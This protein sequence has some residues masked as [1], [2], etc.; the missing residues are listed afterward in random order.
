MRNLILFTICISLTFILSSDW[1]PDDPAKW[2]Q[3]PDTSTNGID[4]RMDRSD[5]VQRTL[6][7]DFEC[8]TTELITDI[9][10]WGSW[11]WDYVA[12]INW[13]ELSIWS[14]APAGQPDPFSHPD[15]LL[16]SKTFYPGDW[17]QRLYYTLPGQD[18]E[19]W[20]DPY[21]GDLDPMGD[22]QI[23][24]Y[25]FFIEEADA[26]MQTGTTANPIIYWLVIKT[27]IS[28]WEGESFGWKTR[29]YNEHFNDDAVRYNPF[30]GGW[31]ELRYP[32]GHPLY[33][34]SIDLSFVITGQEDPVDEYDLGDA[35]EG[36]GKI[37]YPSTMMPG[38]FP[39]CINVLPSGYVIHGPGPLFSYFGQSYDLESDGDAG[40][41]PNCFPTYDDDECFGDGDAGLIIPDSYT[42]DP[43]INVVTC[44]LSAGSSLGFPCA[45]A[46]WGTDID[47]DVQNQSTADRFVNVLFDWNQNGY[48][49][50]DAST[51]CLGTMTPEHVLV[52]FLVP[53]GYT[54]PLSGLTPPSFVIGPNT[55]Y[56]WSRFTISDIPVTFGEWDGSGD[57]GDGETED[58]LLHVEEETL[59]EFDF[60]DAP[61]GDN[62]IAYPSLGV[63]GSFPTC[64][65]VGPSGYIQ[66]GFGM[67][68]AWF[69]Q[70]YDL[71]T[72]GDAGLCPNC[73]PT[74]DDDE[75]FG[76]GD[77]G[78]L[79]PD[80]YTINGVN[81]VIYCPMTTPLGDLG[82][83]CQTAV[84]G[85]DIDIDVTNTMPVDGYVNVLFDWNQDGFW[86]N[87]PLS[88]CAGIMTPEHVL[89]NFG[90][91][92]GYSGPLSGLLPPSFMIGPNNGYVW[93][94]FSITEAQVIND[95]DGS[96]VF[97]DGETE[98]YLLYVEE[99]TQEELDFG[100][101]PD[102]TYPTLSA[103]SGAAHY[104]NSSI[105]LGVNIDPE[106]DGWQDPNALGDDNNGIDDEDG[107]I[108]MN[109][110]IIGETTIIQVTVTSTGFLNVWFDWGIDGTWMEAID[111]VFIDQTLTAGTHFLNVPVPATA[112]S[113][114]TFARFRFD[115][116][117]G[118]SYTGTASDGEV[119]DYEIKIEEFDFGDAPDSYS[120][121]FTSNG[122]RHVF[123]GINYLGSLV[124]TEPEGQPSVGADED[125][126]N[127]SDDEDG[128]IFPVPLIPGEQGAVYVT[129]STMGYL[130]AWMDFD[131]S[132]NWDATEQI[133]TDQILN[134]IWQP[135]N[136]NI[137]ASAIVGD[138]YVRFRFSTT[139]GLS[140]NDVALD[141]EVEDYLVEIIEDPHDG[142][143]MHFHQW[144]DTTMFGIDVN[145]SYEEQFN[146]I[147][148]D[149]FLC[150]ETGPI[151]S[152]H[153]WGSYWYD[154]GYPPNVELGIWTDDPVGQGWSQPDQLLWQQT[155]LTGQYTDNA[156]SYVDDGEHWYDPCTNNL[157]FPGDWI[158]WEYTFS[159]PD[160]E[161]FFQEE[162][163]IYW[164]SVRAWY[165][166]PGSAFFGWK[167][168]PN[169]WNDD[170]VYDCV[171]PMGP[172]LE[173]T[174]PTMHP[175]N[176]VGEEHISVDLAFFI[177]CNPQIPQNVMIS[178]DGVNITLQWD[179]SYCTAYYNVYS[180]TDPYA[181]F[182]SGWTLE[183]T[184]TQI[185]GTTWSETLVSAGD[186]KFYRITAEN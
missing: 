21:M 20:W 82:T 169:H 72:D 167:T 114:I 155:F 80:T 19:W 4:I 84:W 146:R 133:I 170:S 6:G 89:V 1:D 181:A 136:F 154:D 41:C 97:E 142:S 92:M 96:G 164:L 108:F 18:Y 17:V 28:A 16:W 43:T 124:D 3:L 118:L 88:Q 85:T 165:D 44:P 10:F 90:I 23:Y 147:L 76:D 22:Q 81:T 39:T 145:V 126:L 177:D 52:N 75:C 34:Q 91:P 25:N 180:S 116:G 184:G 15:A 101:A 175:F 185:T 47:I 173:M 100:D 104:I 56:F 122:A 102:P 125:D 68:W 60:G 7:D 27:D 109:D 143:K 14:D 94:R 161:A 166:V 58:Y 31:Q 67:N 11:R 120:T 36:E 139:T 74:Y 24:Q 106:P 77:A 99:E 176:P 32:L 148:A 178:E 152:I 112:I 50:D 121:Y 48:W 153:L 12:D 5:D 46:V 13:I 29:D 174:Y 115:T 107:V 163:T 183:P 73:F 62:K 71:E 53:A 86:Q 45:N 70:T 171:Y 33:D 172:W 138:T 119:E 156:Y 131:A 42:I 9:H 83:M 2:Y 149:D 157:I 130:S 57:F 150:T 137:P 55:G 8:T 66:H 54:G 59:E 65:T 103:N 159:V 134:P 117:G 111:H 30:A 113:G 87:D 64:V 179:T 51:T 40:L 128:V 49:Q 158:V 144:P 61:E 110:F 168:S 63:Q 26:F 135:I 98:D 151:N 186:M 78:L 140:F 38:Y 69:G 35:P 162:N 129:A 132:G 160:S 93:C 105:V 182:P 123:D 127:G 37:A 141:G 79:Y 95:W